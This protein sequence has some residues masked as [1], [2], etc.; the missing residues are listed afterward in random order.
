VAVISHALWQRRY[1]GDANAV[2]REI[3]INGEKYFVIGIMPRD[4][5]FR[6]RER[7]FPHSLFAGRP[8]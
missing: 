4:F 6:D 3:L 2:N 5:A 7:D 1:A 8:G